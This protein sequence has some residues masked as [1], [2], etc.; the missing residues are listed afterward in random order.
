MMDFDSTKQVPMLRFKDDQGK[1][2]PKWV[3]QLLGNCAE[4]SKGKGISKDEIVENGVKQCIRYGEL[5]THYGEVITSIISRT[6]TTDSHLVFSMKNDVI[7]PASGETA[8]DI[9]SAFCVLLD[10]VALGGDIN[11]IRS[12]QNGVFLAYYLNSKKREMSRYAQG[13]S[14]IHL[15][16]TNLKRLELSLPCSKE[17]QKIANFLSSVDTRIEQLEKK[18]SLLEQYKKGLMQKLFSQEIRFRDDQ[19]EEYPEWEEIKLGHIGF[20]KSGVGFP[21]NEQGGSEGIPFF[22]VSDMNLPENQRTMK[23]SNNYVTQDQ[24]TKFRWKVIESPA[25]VFAKVGAAIFLERKRLAQTF[26]IDNNMMAFAPDGNVNFM[27]YLFHAIRLSK[28]AQTGALPS[29][30]QG[31]LELVRKFIPIVAEEQQKIANILS[32]VDKN[33]ELVAEQINQTREF[34]KGLLQQMF[35]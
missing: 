26:L 11:I 31:D 32:T 35:V 22:K 4:F 24:I 5:Y 28:Y 1:E 17:Q 25:I 7:V 20:F 13:I 6:N 9:A 29:Y 34:K 30:N 33:I 21:N 18:K 10:K 14:V 19:G 27:I 15:Y 3:S 16:T 2:Y 23:F 12:K 8:L